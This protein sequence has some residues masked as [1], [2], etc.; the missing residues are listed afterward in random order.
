[1]ARPLG[2]GPILVYLGFGPPAPILVGLPPAAY[3]GSPTP[4]GP[5]QA[6]YYGTTRSGV[7]TDE[8]L[9]FYQ[10]MNDLSG[11]KLSL[12]DGYAGRED[13][14][15]LTMSSWSQAVD[16]MIE[17]FLRPTAA[18]PPARAV[19]PGQ[20]LSPGRGVDALTDLGTLMVSEG[21]SIGI[22]LVRA[23]AGKPVN[24]A[25]GLGIGR[26]YYTCVMSGP[27]KLIEGNKENLR[28]RVFTAKKNIAA[29]NTGSL[30][31]FSEDPL[32]FAGLPPPT[33][34]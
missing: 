2:S 32:D 29:L 25:S 13:R 33:Y 4:V 27:N 3:A 22:W 26:Y 11:P 31:L 8:D 17:Q 21:K 18:F 5:A 6:L 14:L 19:I 24:V 9:A 7:D 16:N 28:V 20:P 12:D 1:M 23:A 15:A 34:G 10:V 30:P